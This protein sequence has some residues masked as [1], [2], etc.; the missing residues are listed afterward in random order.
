MLPRTELLK[1]ALAHARAG[2]K[3]LYDERH[4]PVFRLGME[5]EMIGRFIPASSYYA[6]EKVESMTTYELRDAGLFS[7]EELEFIHEMNE[8]NIL[9]D[10]EWVEA[11]ERKVDAKFETGDG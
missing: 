8:I 6:T 7:D 2:A 10:D 9:D 1:I 3:Y 5:T 11:L 4:I